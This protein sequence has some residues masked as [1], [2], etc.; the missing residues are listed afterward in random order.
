MTFQW[1]SEGTSIILLPHG[2]EGKRVFALAEEWTQHRLLAPALYVFAEDQD[3]DAYKAFEETGP[4][5]INASVTGRDGRCD[6]SLFDEL[7][8]NEIKTIKVLACRLV[9]SHE[10]FNKQQ[11]QM[12]DRVREQVERSAPLREEDGQKVIGTKIIRLNLIAGES[13]QSQGSA[14]HLLEMDWDANIILSPEDRSTPSGFDTFTDS[15]EAH[16]PGFLLSNIASTA[17]LWTG[18]N[19][20]V[21]EL[22]NIATSGA[23]DKVFVQRTFGRAVKTDTLA[24]RLASNALKTIEDTGSP[25]TDPTY[26]LKDK[27]K[28]QTTEIPTLISRMVEETLKADSGA[29]A[30]NLSLEKAK[31][32]G[33]K[34]LSFREGLKLFVK[35]FWDKLMALPRQ[36][37]DMV[38]ETFNRKAT[39]TLF[40]E[41][42]G[43]AI[44]ARKDFRKFGL[45]QKDAEDL[46]KLEDVKK[47]VGSTLDGLPIAPDYRGQHPTLW[48]AI[49]K[50]MVGS[51]EGSLDG[52]LNEFNGRVLVDAERLIPKFGHIWTVPECV[53]DPEEDP[54]EVKSTLEWLDVA[55]AE[56][57][58]KYINGNVEYSKKTIEEHRN[59]LLEAETERD[60]S[61]T[62]VKDTRKIREKLIDRKKSLALI[63]E[64]VDHE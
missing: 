23:Y 54:E 12:V 48:A 28:M 36:L 46:I 49:R 44:E 52:E 56:K 3:D 5:K 55:A 9:D 32:E 59:E 29:L 40:G 30:F 45:Q 35:F 13:T 27:L 10:S 34:K 58:S 8:R 26:N 22:Q 4:V 50:M 63:V 41:D 57:I 31:A 61:K 60:A 43:Y 25:L 14:E 24:I 1:P 42:S 47:L 18:V 51:L 21:L 19:R 2:E 16:Y 53:I 11:D 15:S 20:S 7:G 64:G 33:I 37:V 39:K 17:G 62:N 38:I 6:V